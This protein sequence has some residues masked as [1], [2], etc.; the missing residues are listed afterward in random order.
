MEVSE[1]SM[2]DHKP[3]KIN[4]INNEEIVSLLKNH[5]DSELDRIENYINTENN[6]LS[7][8]S[9][10]INNEDDGQQKISMGSLRDELSINRYGSYEFDI[11]NDCIKTTI[12]VFRKYL[13]QHYLFEDENG[14]TELGKRYKK[15]TNAVLFYRLP[16]S[17]KKELIRKEKLNNLL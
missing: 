2:D 6:N 5:I 13:T 15:I 10:S 4:N 3:E 8:H 7:K 1:K 11:R 14:E 17:I 9:E 16:D 12:Y